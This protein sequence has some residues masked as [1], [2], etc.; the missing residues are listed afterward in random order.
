MAR[1]QKDNFHGGQ[2]VTGLE[3]DIE[4]AA[5]NRQHNRDMSRIGGNLADAPADAVFGAAKTVGLGA[6]FGGFFIYRL[7]RNPRS[8]YKLQA[9]GHLFV[10]LF[11]SG[12][13]LSIVFPPIASFF[14]DSTD[15]D[16]WKA[17]QPAYYGITIIIAVVWT[18]A[19]VWLRTLPK[20]RRLRAQA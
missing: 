9:V 3:R 16:A 11:V 20:L 19:Y 5:K 7:L 13:V 15:Q 17:A 12:W 4:Q 8:R 10:A 14:I 2:R 6:L 1:I 18:A